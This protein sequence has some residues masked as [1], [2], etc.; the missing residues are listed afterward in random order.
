MPKRNR[1]VEPVAVLLPP[2]IQRFLTGDDLR[3][4]AGCSESHFVR[5]LKLGKIPK[6]DV[7]LGRVGPRW[8]PKTIERWVNGE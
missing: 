6:P 2:G 7:D 8:R 4:I 3:H 5:L 1:T